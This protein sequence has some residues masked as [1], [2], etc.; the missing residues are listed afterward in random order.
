MRMTDVEAH[1]TLYYGRDKLLV[2]E[3]HS[4]MEEVVTGRSRKGE[5]RLWP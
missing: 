5:E 4:F 3:R 2:N 1:A